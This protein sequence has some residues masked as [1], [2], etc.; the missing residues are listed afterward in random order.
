MVIRKSGPL[1]ARWL[2]LRLLSARANA[3]SAVL[4]ARN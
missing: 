1:H 4:S 3:A 2:Q